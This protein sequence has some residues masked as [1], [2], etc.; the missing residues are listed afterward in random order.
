[1]TLQLGSEALGRL[2][3][4]LPTGW[5][6]STG[7]SLRQVPFLRL[8]Q[9]GPAPDEK[10]LHQGSSFTEGENHFLC[11][12]LPSLHCP[13]F[14]VSPLT[15]WQWLKKYPYP[16]TFAPAP[17]TCYTTLVLPLLCISIKFKKYNRKGIKSQVCSH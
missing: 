12:S 15:R 17:S 2:P 13:S 11:L 16:Y 14:M 1:M 5:K 7:A 10:Q 3:P 9:A 8:L 4:A 6:R